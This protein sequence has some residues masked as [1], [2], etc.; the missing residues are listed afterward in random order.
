MWTELTSVPWTR[1]S[2]VSG[3]DTLGQRSSVMRAVGVHG[4]NLILVLDQQHLSALNALDFDLLFL[5]ILKVDLGQIL[6]LEFGSHAAD[7]GG[8][9]C[10][11]EGDL[12]ESC[13]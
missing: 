4:M 7:G 12:R 9:G 10:L 2:S 13:D 6:E 1:Q 3:N 11:L 8:E 5:A